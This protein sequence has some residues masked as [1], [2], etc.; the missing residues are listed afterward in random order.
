V[1]AVLDGPRG[2]AQELSRVSRAEPDAVLLSKELVTI[3]CHVPLELDLAAMETQ[4][5]D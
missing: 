1:E 2:E 3:D 4:P 5:P